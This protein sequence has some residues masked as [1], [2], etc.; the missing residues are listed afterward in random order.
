[1]HDI[2]V[3]GKRNRRWQLNEW[4]IVCLH[5]CLHVACQPWSLVF[6]SSSVT[7]LTPVMKIFSKILLWMKIRIVDG[8]SSYLRMNI[9]S[10]HISPR[11]SSLPS[12]HPSLSTHLMKHLSLH[13]RLRTGSADTILRAIEELTCKNT[14]FLIYRARMDC[15]SCSE[16]INGNFGSKKSVSFDTK[17]RRHEQRR[18]YL[19]F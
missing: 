12:R 19:H 13:P 11:Y 2:V 7:G 8:F 5:T 16:E 18:R 10:N 1:M 14:T 15:D 3:F 4:R 6:T 17:L 9:T